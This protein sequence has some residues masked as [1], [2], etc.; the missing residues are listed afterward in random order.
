MPHR[1]SFIG[2]AAIEIE[3]TGGQILRFILPEG[4]SVPEEFKVGDEVAIMVYP[5]HPQFNK[6]SYCEIGHVASKKVI[7]AFY[8]I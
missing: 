6:T 7:K 1:I 3:K 8:K 2:T 5:A 4:C